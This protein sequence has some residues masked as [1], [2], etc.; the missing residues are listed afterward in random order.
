MPGGARWDR[1]E[2]KKTRKKNIFFYC[3]LCTSMYMCGSRIGPLAQPMP[4]CHLG[5]MD[6]PV[7]TS[8]RRQSPARAALAAV[9]RWALAE[10]K[11]Q[12]TRACRPGRCVALKQ[13]LS[14]GGTGRYR[15]P[16]P[17]QGALTR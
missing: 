9:G 10:L 6:H 5:T 14:P 11:Q 8:A 16:V 7:A 3:Y 4:A 15:V 1:K 17:V 12:P 2:K 13:N